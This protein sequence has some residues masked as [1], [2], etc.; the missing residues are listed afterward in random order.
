MVK[1]SAYNL[2]KRRKENMTVKVIENYN[3]R[4]RAGGVANDGSKLSIFVKESVAKDLAKKGGI[5]IVNK[6]YRKR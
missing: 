1:V 3:R 6:T 4:Y 5:K 2:S